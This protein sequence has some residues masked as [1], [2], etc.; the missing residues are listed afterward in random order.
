MTHKKAVILFGIVAVV[1][2]AIWIPKAEA[3]SA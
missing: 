3:Y 1:V 2:L